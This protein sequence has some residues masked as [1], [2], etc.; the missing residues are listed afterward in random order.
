MAKEGTKQEVLLPQR[1]HP[2]WSASP[3][4]SKPVRNAVTEPVRSPSAALRDLP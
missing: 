4:Q 3:V 2:R 1:V